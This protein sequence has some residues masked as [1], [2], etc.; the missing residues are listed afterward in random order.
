MELS[1]SLARALALAIGFMHAGRGARSGRT[2]VGAPTAQVKHFDPKGN[3]PSKYTI[4]LRKGVSATLPFEDRRDSRRP[5][6]ASSPSR[7]S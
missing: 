6:K 2:L 7:P 5:R 4:E 3:L 1:K